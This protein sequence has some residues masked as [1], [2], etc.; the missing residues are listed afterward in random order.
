MTA[1][2]VI[3]AVCAVTGLALD[4]G[5]FFT[6]ASSS[7]ELTQTAGDQG[8]IVSGKAATAS[9]PGSIAVGARGTYTEAGGVTLQ[10]AKNVTVTNVDPDVLKAQLAA[11]L[12]AELSGN[13]T[14]LEAFHEA[15]TTQASTLGSGNE[16]IANALG[17][18]GDLLQSQQTGGQTALLKPLVI[19]GLA[20]AVVVIFIFRK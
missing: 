10:G 4:A 3:L 11:N 12:A 14:L 2:L 1:L 19:L 13:Q 5:G 18:L 20:V 9:S 6:S 15:Q 7:K 17:K 8:L 16:A